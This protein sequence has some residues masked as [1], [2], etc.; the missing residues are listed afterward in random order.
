MIEDSILKSTKKILGLSE[1]Y[2]AFDL[3]II[4]HINSAISVLSQIGVGPG[5]GFAIED[6]SAVWS[7]LGELGDATNLIKTYLY[8]KVRILFDPPGT[9]YLIEALNKQLEEHEARISIF[10]EAR[11][12]EEEVV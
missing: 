4:T 1:Q 7:D 8:L 3:D 9:S 6:E 5:G 2:N 10:R 12:M 11:L